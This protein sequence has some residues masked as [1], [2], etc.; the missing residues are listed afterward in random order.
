MILGPD[1]TNMS[2]SKGNVVNPEE[3]LDEFGADSLRQALL[4]ITIGSDFP[5]KWDTVKYGKGFLQKYWSAARFAH[6]F[7]KNYDMM[8][9]RPK[10]LTA[11]DRWILSKLTKTIKT[12]TL[13][14]DTYEF[15]T[16]I[17]KLR[18]FFWHT[19]CD[20]YV[21]AIKHRLYDKIS[22]TDHAAALHS[23][24]TVLWNTT[25]LLAPFCPHITEEVNSKLF[26][27]RLL[28]IHEA[29]WPEA[30]ELPQDDESEEDGDLLM[31]VIAEIRREKS[32]AGIPLSSPLKRILLTLREE[33]SMTVKGLQDEVKKIL[34]IED[35]VFK[36]G[37]KLQVKLDQI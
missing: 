21:E 10:N 22:D 1:G 36:K 19:F 31:E 11:L 5:F 32:G 2:K 34:H 35:I 12:I 9:E 33:D 7:I 25:L 27:G 24:F 18:G 15:H 3:R 29:E 17:R 23:L 30:D 13:A 28:S 8:D 14:M 26:G 37:S 20:Q 4:S 16:A 6:P